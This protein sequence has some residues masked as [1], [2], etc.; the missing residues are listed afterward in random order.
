MAELTVGVV[1]GVG[2]IFLGLGTGALVLTTITTAGLV[3]V[4][5]GLFV[6]SFLLGACI[7]EKTR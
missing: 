2:G 7:A 1:T 6:A 4:L 5:G 3:L